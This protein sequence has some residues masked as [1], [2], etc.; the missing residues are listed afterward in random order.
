MFNIFKKV[1]L[2]EDQIKA[3]Y[4][5]IEALEKETGTS[6]SSYILSWNINPMTLAEKVAAIMDYLNLE[7][8]EQDR[9][10]LVPKK[11]DK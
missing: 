8:H 7:E 3:L 2:Q 9:H 5:R 6:F 10:C 1:K 4:K 11:K